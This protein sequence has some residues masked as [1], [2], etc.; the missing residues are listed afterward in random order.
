MTTIK[1]ANVTWFGELFR[2]QAAA[3]SVALC[4]TYS[5]HYK[6]TCLLTLKARSPTVVSQVQLTICDEHDC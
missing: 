5:A 2:I 6:F 3:D 1:D 4:L